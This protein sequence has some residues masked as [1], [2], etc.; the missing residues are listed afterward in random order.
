MAGLTMACIDYKRD[1]V[2]RCRKY[3]KTVGNSMKK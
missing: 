3:A 2:W 1:N